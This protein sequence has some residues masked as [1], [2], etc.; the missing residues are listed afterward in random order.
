MTQIYVIPF[1]E[2]LGYIQEGDRFDED[3]GMSHVSAMPNSYRMMK[4]L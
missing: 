3:G 1:Y 2:K 4:I